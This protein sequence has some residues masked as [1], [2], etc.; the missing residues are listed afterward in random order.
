MPDSPYIEACC[1]LNER[2]PRLRDLWLFLWHI[3][4]IYALWHK[5][6]RPARP[7]AAPALSP[8]PFRCAL[9]ALCALLPIEPLSAPAP[10]PARPSGAL[11][12]TRP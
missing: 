6:T 7:V 12:G 5:Q 1:R 2:F 11:D 8:G 4:I 9:D 3:A 10:A